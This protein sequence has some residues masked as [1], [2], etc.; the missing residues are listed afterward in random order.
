MTDNI[1][2]YSCDSIVTVS[3]GLPYERSMPSFIFIQAM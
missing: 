2:I 1:M 3:V